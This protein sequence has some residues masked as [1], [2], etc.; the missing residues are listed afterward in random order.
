MKV[1]GQCIQGDDDSEEKILSNSNVIDL[2][3]ACLA[4]A[5]FFDVNGLKNFNVFNTFHAGGGGKH[6]PVSF[7]D[8][9]HTPKVL[10]S[11]KSVNGNDDVVARKNIEGPINSF[12]CNTNNHRPVENFQQRAQWRRKTFDNGLFCPMEQLEST[13]DANC[14]VK[15]PSV[16]NH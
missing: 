15:M 16:Q 7:L 8:T 14:S 10:I 6:D 3:L 1:D 4:P 12:D 11:S 13:F 5:D 2:T 9:G